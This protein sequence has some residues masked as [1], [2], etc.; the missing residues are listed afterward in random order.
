MSIDTL[1]DWNARLVPAQ[2]QDSDLSD[3]VWPGAGDCGCC[4]MPGCC[5]PLL[6]CQSGFVRA[7]AHGFTDPYSDSDSSVPVLY[8][9]KVIGQREIGGER[10]NDYPHNEPS[11]GAQWVRVTVTTDREYEEAEEYDPWLQISIS[12]AYF[13]GSCVSQDFVYLPRVCTY[14]GTR[15]TENYAIHWNGSSWDRY[16]ASEYV[17]TNS[18][19]EGDTTEAF[20]AWRDEFPTDEDYETALSDYESEHAT[21][22]TENDAYNQAW[23]DY[24]AA[25]AEWDAGGQVGPEPEEPTLDPPGDEPTPPSERPEQETYGPC[26]LKTVTVFRRWD[27]VFSGGAVTGTTLAEEETT[28]SY[29]TTSNG[30]SIADGSSVESYGPELQNPITEAEFLSEVDAWVA[31][32]LPDVLASWS[33]DSGS[34]SIDCRPG[35]LCYASR[36]APFPYVYAEDFFRYRWKLNKC[37]G[38]YSALSWLEV[39][40][41]EDEACV[42]STADSQCSDI[43]VTNKAWEWTGTGPDSACD[44]S[45]TSGSEA[46]DEFDDETRWSPWSAVVQ[47]PDGRHGTTVLRELHML[48]WRSSRYGQK[49]ERMDVLEYYDDES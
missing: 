33:D 4:E 17:Q 14:S 35:S 37:C 24:D 48:C 47:V 31:T 28:T 49:P 16:K 45:D 26:T 15:T 39:F 42:D 3:S 23:D 38:S 12:G 20:A 43:I 25:W 9:K 11:P 6:E 1:Q 44:A 19:G 18:S 7:E 13:S 5:P 46:F 21:W 2:A 29:S 32:N 41:A 27:P 40:F 34:D 8:R 30:M 22:T 36:G 10:L